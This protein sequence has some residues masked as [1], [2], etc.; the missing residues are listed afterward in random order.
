MEHYTMGQLAETQTPEQNRA[1]VAELERSEDALRALPGSRGDTESNQLP[2]ARTLNFD[3]SETGGES[4]GSSGVADIGQ[5][6]RAQTGSN[7]W[8]SV[9]DFAKSQGYDVGQHTDERQF[10]Q[11]LLRNSQARQQED[12]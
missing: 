5:A 3:G 9:L 2:Q 1:A 6:A 4:G 12:Y 11:S 7:D 10:I 8:E